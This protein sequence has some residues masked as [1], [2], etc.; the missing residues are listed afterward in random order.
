MRGS[1]AVAFQTERRPREMTVQSQTHGVHGI[2]I[3]Q[4]TGTALRCSMEEE[5]VHLLISEIR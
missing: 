1:T 3:T 2:H 5:S 4:D